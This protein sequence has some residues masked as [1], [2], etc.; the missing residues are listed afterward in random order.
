MNGQTEHSLFWASLM[1]S[2]LLD[3]K[4]KYIAF[5]CLLHGPKKLT[6]TMDNTTSD[7]WI[8]KHMTCLK[9]IQKDCSRRFSGHL[10]AALNLFQKVGDM[11]ACKT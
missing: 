5:L 6:Y 11:R 1:F 2:S 9:L 8:L 10:K 3:F 7:L 4:H